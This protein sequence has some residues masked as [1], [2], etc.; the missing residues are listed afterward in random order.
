MQKDNDS[1][2]EER[3][4]KG[5]QDELSDVW[6]ELLGLYPGENPVPAISDQQTI[7]MLEGDPWRKLSEEE[8][9]ELVDL[10]QVHLPISD[11]EV[12]QMLQLMQE[13]GD[14]NDGSKK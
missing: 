14:G 3:H 13:Q 1:K 10:E 11:R 12:E 9:F 5:D 6:R 4:R 7:P 2:H 8:T